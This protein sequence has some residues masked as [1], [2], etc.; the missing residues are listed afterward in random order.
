M[1]YVVLQSMHAVCIYLYVIYL[2]LF[3]WSRK[4]SKV[5]NI[6]TLYNIL[7]TFWTFYLL[8][9]RV[10]SLTNL[11]MIQFSNITGSKETDRHSWRNKNNFL[12]E[13]FT[14]LFSSLWWR[15]RKRME[16]IAERKS[17]FF[18]IKALVKYTRDDS[19]ALEIWRRTWY[20]L[21]FKYIIWFWA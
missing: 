5:L 18:S 10:L 4:S 1:I 2:F 17:N 9:P 19:N 13:L 14:S 11:D 16:E 7:L 3:R 12:L 20:I 8:S 15:R 21:S 6:L